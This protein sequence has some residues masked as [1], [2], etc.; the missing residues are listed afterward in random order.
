M[1]MRKTALLLSIVGA[2]FVAQPA[3]SQTA[4]GAAVTRTSCSQWDDAYLGLSE[5][6]IVACAVAAFLLPLVFGLIGRRFWLA[7][8]PRL[9]ILVS[10]VAVLAAAALAIV[11]LPQAFGF[12][13]GWLSGIG[14]R[15]FDWP[16]R[17]GNSGGHP[18]GNDPR[19]SSGRQ[20]GRGTRLVEC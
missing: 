12:E 17:S 4:S 15:Y 6:S 16:P 19:P 9:R 7:A 20:P 14:V 2:L 18:M 3:S 5:T 13:W 8:A 1:K 11:G 10:G